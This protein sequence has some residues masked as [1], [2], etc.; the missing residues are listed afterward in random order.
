[1][2]KKIAPW[3]FYSCALDATPLPWD[4][5]E[6]SCS[7]ASSA[8]S[9][10][11]I[12]LSYQKRRAS[13]QV[14]TQSSNAKVQCKKV[15]VMEYDMCEFLHKCVDKYKD[16]AG[17]NAPKMQRVLTPYP[18]QVQLAAVENIEGEGVLASIAARI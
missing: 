5:R 16:L 2:T 17:P 8:D 6:T 15:A 10:P 1:M 14:P 18:N 13:G 11:A 9:C 12:A 4:K 7:S 3:P